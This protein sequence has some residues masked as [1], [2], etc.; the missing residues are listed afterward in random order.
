MAEI[1]VDIKPRGI[2]SAYKNASFDKG[3]EALEKE[4]YRIISLQEN[5]RLRMQEGKDADVSINGNWVREGAIYVPNKGIFL[6]KDSP[7]MA[8]AKEATDCHR[9][10]KDFYLT[11]EQV[12]KA[13]ADSVL[14]SVKSIPTNKF[15]DNDITAY[16]FGEDAEEYGQ[17][18]REAGIEKMPVQLADIQEK[19]FARQVWF[20]RLGDGG[21]SVLVCD[22][23]GLFHGYGRVRGVRDSTEGTAKNFEA[24]T[25]NQ[26]AKVL[27]KLKVSGLEESILTELRNQ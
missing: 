3:K 27:G 16:A 5:A 26:I 22:G 11:N 9:N 20:G 21:R 6:T 15:A 18:L 14:L 4:G 25:P 12:E 13:L 17:F 2:T 1:I 24:Y 7:I 19:P 23:R 10:R 8:N